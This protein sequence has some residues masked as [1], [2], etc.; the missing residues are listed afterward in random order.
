MAAYERLLNLRPRLALVNEQAYSAGLVRHYLDAGYVGIV[1]EWDN[2][3]A[4]HP[5][6]SGVLRYAPQRALG[7][8]GECIPLV[9]NQ[10]IAFQK[11]QRYAHGEYEL[12]EYLDAIRARRGDGPRAWSLYGN[13][14]E[15]FDFR[16]GRYHT[17]AALGSASEWAR[18]ERLYAALAR[19]P[20]IELILPGAVLDRL[21][22]PGAGQ[23][24][25]LTT[26]ARPVSCF[27]R[28][29]IRVP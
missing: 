29:M 3:A 12:D 24:L 6:W 21:S 10:S 25:A 19:E 28:C 26:A 4:A 22:A 2:A 8:A 15:I 17:E 14:A 5:Q 20:G 1:M 18:I 16:P 13:D 27:S 9:W 11:F 7:T 23:P